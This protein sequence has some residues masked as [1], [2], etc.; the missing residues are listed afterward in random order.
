ML[1][2]R[3]KH[4]CIG[5]STVH[6]YKHCL[7]AQVHRYKHRY[8]GTSTVNRCKHRYI[9][10]STGYKHSAMSALQSARND[11]MRINSQRNLGAA[12]EQAAVRLAGP[13]TSHG[14]SIH[15]ELCQMHETQWIRLCEFVPCCCAPNTPIVHHVLARFATACEMA[16]QHFAPGHHCSIL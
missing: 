10:T 3:Y 9:G 1:S 2:A 7:Q 11:K 16:M 15:C 13:A 6:G 4:R 12:M 14:C 8:V 5:T